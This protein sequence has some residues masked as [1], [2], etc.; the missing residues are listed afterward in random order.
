MFYFI[1][2][3]ALYLILFVG[4]SVTIQKGF[5]H[6]YMPDE[7]MQQTGDPTSLTFGMP[8]LNLQPRETQSGLILSGMVAQ[9]RRDWGKAWQSFSRLNEK[10]EGNPTIALRAFTLALGNGAFTQAETI[11]Q[12]LKSDYF[13]QDSEETSFSTYDL[14]RL[15]TVLMD[16]KSQNLEQAALGLEA[17]NEGALA[18]FAKPIMNAWIKPETLDKSTDKLGSLQIYYKAAGAEYHQKYDIADTLFAAFEKDAFSPDN[19]IT[20]AG[21]HVRRDNIDVAIEVLKR[22]LVRF[23][24]DDEIR[25]MMETLQ[26][27]P[28]S[29]APLE[30][31][32]YHLKA[33]ENPLGMAFHNFAQA[34]VQ[35]GA[36]DSALLFAQMA[37]YLDPQSP[38]AHVTIGN[39]LDYQGQEDDALVAYKKVRVND[40]QY[41]TALTKKIDILIEREHNAEAAEYL[42]QDIARDPNNAYSHYLLGNIYKADNQFAKA[43][44]SYDVA[45]AL[46]RHDGEL[47]R[48]LWPLYYSRAIAFDLND[49]WDKAEAD[50][51]VAMDKFPNSPII[52]NYLGYAYADR[53]IKLEEAKEMISKAVMAAPNDAYIIDSMG[54]ILYRMGFYDQSV[55][56]L[57]RAVRM[58]PYHMVIN[59]HLGDAYWKVGRKI[60]AHYMWQRAIDYFDEDDE[61]QSR[62]IDETRRK[63]KE[64]L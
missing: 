1:R 9:N 21:Y 2:T 37:L 50:L 26:N 54:W 52:L 17:L 56:Y 18:D 12:S 49:E 31:A 39:I 63:V 35:D 29:Y 45:E 33:I 24:N 28:E 23:N 46:G 61:E 20:V 59:D 34:M 6:Y 62:M 10:Y 55:N 11:A 22:G 44:E 7:S 25:D 3:I 47:D 43:I 27:N 4:V 42:H 60:E 16:I 40:P 64:G 53:G 38:S 48:K 19:I 13:D 30:F 15:F 36:L 14:V 57:E 58:R 5:Q 32:D 8:R 41:E 51:I